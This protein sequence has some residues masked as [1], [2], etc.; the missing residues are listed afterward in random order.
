MTR[1]ISRKKLV[2][3]AIVVATLGVL[4]RWSPSY[5]SIRV[6]GGADGDVTVEQGGFGPQRAEVRTKAGQVTSQAW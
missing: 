1:R 3:L 4:S 5:V 6:T 2:I